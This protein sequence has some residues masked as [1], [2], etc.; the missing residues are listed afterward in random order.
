MPND[1]DYIERSLTAHEAFVEV[2]DAAS[3]WLGECNQYEEETGLVG[4]LAQVIEQS[5]QIIL[6]FYLDQEI[7]DR[8]FIDR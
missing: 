2:L 7:H 1:Y 3:A 8:Y 5:M 6:A 4:K